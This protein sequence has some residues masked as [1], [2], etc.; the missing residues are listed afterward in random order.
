MFKK[1]RFWIP[2]VSVAVLL[3][4]AGCRAAEPT[5]VP[6]TAPAVA[7]TAPAVATT[8]PAVATTAPAVA[9]TAPVELAAYV[10]P[11]RPSGVLDWAP[12][13]I[14]DVLSEYP[15]RMWWYTDIPKPTTQPKY[16]GT[17]RRGGPWATG[18]AGVAHWDVRTSGQ[19]AGRGSSICY[20]RLLTFQQDW[21]AESRTTPFPQKDAADSWKVLEDGLTWEFKLNPE[22][23]F[24]DIAPVNGRRV[25]AED[26]KFNIEFFRD[27]SA[28]SGSFQIITDVEV[29]D[30]TTLHVKTSETYAFLPNL[31][32]GAG[33]QMFAPE[34]LDEPG[35]TKT[36]CIGWGP[37][38]LVEYEPNGNWTVERHNKY[39]L[40]G[41]TGMR[42]PYVDRV[43][44]LSFGD[45]A[46]TYAAMQTNR[47]HLMTAS[48]LGDLRTI[49]NSNSNING[50]IMPM[51]PGAH[52]GIALNMTKAPL[53]DVRVRRALTMGMDLQPIIDT[54]FQGSAM[55]AQQIPLDAIGWDTGPPIA[56]RGPYQQ[57]DPVKGKE[58]LAEAG[59]PEGLKLTWTVSATSGPDLG[60]WE[61]IIFQWE[62]NLGVEVVLDVNEYVQ[63]FKKAV[64]K[65]FEDLINTASTSN[66]DWDSYIYAKMY[67]KSPG[68]YNWIDDPEVDRLVQE[69]RTT[70]DLEEQ[71]RIAKT[72]FEMEDNNV[73]RINLVE[74]YWYTLWSADIE[75]GSSGL[76]T[77]ITSWVS[78]GKE[79]IWFKN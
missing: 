55:M 61:T 29:V 76:Y 45:A 32:A 54:V 7:T 24:H 30:A 58:L 14:K 51:S 75:N 41:H 6:T 19:P 25:T 5:A 11:D 10:A 33:I 67:S 2:A 36:W 17:L 79:S 56:L 49:L 78:R 44:M 21:L 64:D 34:M 70:L 3:V 28:Y 18:S 74:P 13:A 42:L 8:A 47:T 57:F 38:K 26:L 4:I 52:S 60:M 77:W 69:F 37:F 46:T 50:E 59:Y 31:L 27:E 40:F 16:G 65:D 48:S 71:R 72:L 39:H 66:T 23:Y 43:E 53:N 63:W 15:N 9:T 35:G 12:Q 73:Y 1:T 22:V 20:G 62:K 68:N